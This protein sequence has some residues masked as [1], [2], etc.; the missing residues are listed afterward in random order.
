MIE[1]NTIHFGD[2]L[3]MLRTLPEAYAELIIADPPYSLDKDREFGEGAFF[4]SRE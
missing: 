2:A 1:E 4:N 3:T